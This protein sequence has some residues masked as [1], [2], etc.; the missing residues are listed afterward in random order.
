MRAS[1]ENVL[2]LFYLVYFVFNIT[3]KHPN[4]IL[5]PIN[6]SAITDAVENELTPA[7]TQVANVS[8]SYFN[9]DVNKMYPFSWFTVV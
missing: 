8:T 7:T 6:C 3:I 2:C 9:K 4:Y 1:Q 5:E